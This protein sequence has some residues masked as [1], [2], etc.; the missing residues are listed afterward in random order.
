M[1]ARQQSID[2]G[3]T[4]KEAGMCKALDH[5]NQ[6][7][8]DWSERA[9]SFLREFVKGTRGEFMAEDVRAA[10]EGIVPEPLN[11]KAW[12]GIFFKAAYWKVIERVRYDKV[13]TPTS[14]QANASVW[15][16]V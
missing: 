14:H 3:R 1:T 9:Y 5:A 7:H 2:F 8:P 16:A 11:K 15:R 10:A 13:K 4:L 6:V 12:G